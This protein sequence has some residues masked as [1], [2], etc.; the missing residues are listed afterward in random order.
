MSTMD[1]TRQT[2]AEGLAHARE[3]VQMILRDWDWMTWNELLADA[4]VLSLK[5]GSVGNSRLGDFGAVDGELQIAG[6]ADAKRALKSIYSELKNGFSI[7]T[8][9]VSGYDVALPGNFVVRTTKEDS[10]ASSLPIVLYMAFNSE[11]EIEKMTIPAIDLN[12][13]AKAIRAA[14]QSGSYHLS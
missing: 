7:T 10:E 3:L 1:I 4:I 13:L 12:P 11:G 6:V 8:E 9:I 14:A 2:E 5:L